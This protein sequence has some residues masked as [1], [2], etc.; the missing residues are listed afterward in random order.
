MQEDSLIKPCSP[1]TFFVMYG[2]LFLAIFNYTLSIIASIYIV[3]DLGGGSSTI[4]YNISFFAL[5]NAIGIPLGAYFLS[6]Y[7]I[8]RPLLLCTI[9]FVFFAWTSAVSV[10]YIEFLASRFFQG[11]LCGPYYAFLL[12]LQNL[13]VPQQYKKL[14]PPLNACIFIITP[15]LGACW[16]GWISYE[17]NWRILYHIDTLF[18][19]IFALLQYIYIKGFDAP[20]IK[21]NVNF[22]CIGYLS[23]VCGL[24]A[25]GTVV[26]RGQELDWFRS[27]LITWLFVAGSFS[28]IFFIIWELNTEQPLLNLRLLSNP[29]LVF[30]LFHLAVL[31]ALY[32]GNII[33]LSLWLKFWANYTAWWI[34]LLLI[35]TAISA[36]LIVILR[37]QFAAID[38]RIFWATAIIFLA[39]SCYYT[40]YFNIQTDFERVAIS[41][42]LAGFGLAFFLPPIFRTIYNL[43]PAYFI[44]LVALLQM[45][46]A[47]GSGLGAALFTTLWDRRQVFFNERLVSRL[48]PLSPIT[49]EYLT[50]ANI[51]GL[52][53]ETAI[54][55]LNYF[56]LREASSLALD[57]S[58]YL[59][60]WILTGLLLSFAFTYFIPKR[61][62]NP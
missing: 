42:L 11:L 7:G 23:L 59:M 28:L 61:T 16:G 12:S 62:F 48:T 46:R 53:G 34:N 15:T 3:G 37:A 4:T 49:E 27:D 20:F 55:Q 6:K 25:L 13:I 52:H 24:L 10:T 19:I 43:Y 56:S 29:V 41:R 5:G 22:D 8:R 2:S 1:V 57:D 31:F 39:I 58:F 54:A 33:L 50:Q 32:F 17:W 18:G 21:K 44:D 30:C 47:L 40:T 36:L 9:I 45:T 14:V 51:R 60:F 38:C 26:I 35:N